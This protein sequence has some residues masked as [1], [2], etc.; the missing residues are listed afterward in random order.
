MF[1]DFPVLK[2]LRWDI[3]GSWDRIQL[4]PSAKMLKELARRH[5]EMRPPD[6][7]EF[8]RSGEILV[9]EISTQGVEKLK[10]IGQKVIETARKI[11]P[12]GEKGG[13]A[14]PSTPEG[15][16]PVPPTQESNPPVLEQ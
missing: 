14:S 16:P 3:T 11:I 7:L 13:D 10:A 15:T 5:P 6:T 2:L 12:E 4:Q 1:V 8:V 9:Q